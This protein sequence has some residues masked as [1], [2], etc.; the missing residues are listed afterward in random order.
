MPLILHVEVVLVR[1][2]V[3]GGEPG[4]CVR[5]LVE[6][7]VEALLDGRRRAGQR[8]DC[9]L[10][11]INVGRVRRGA[12][13]HVS[14]R[15][16]ECG[17]NVAQTAQPYGTPEQDAR[18]QDLAAKEAT[19]VIV[20]V[21]AEVNP[22]ADGVRTMRPAQVVNELGRGD[23]ALGVGRSTKRRINSFGRSGTGP[24]R[25]KDAII[26]PRRTLC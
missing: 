1:A 22:G 23:R 2:C 3:Y 10:Q 11:R 5:V 6:I 15:V 17:W 25:T 4:G 20:N 9:L 8:N 21:E 7:G 16:F 13:D 18:G 24:H 12:G 14:A 26:E 19:T